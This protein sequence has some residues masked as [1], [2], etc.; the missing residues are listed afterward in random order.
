M[1]RLSAELQRFFFQQQ[2]LP[3]VQLQELL[4]LTQERTFGLLFVALALPS[5]LPVPA[6]GYAIPFGAVLLLLA[7]QL[8]WG[9]KLPWLPQRVRNYSIELERARHW[10][11]Q[12]LPWLQRIEAVARPRLSFV[13]TSPPGRMAL[14]GAIALMAASMMVPIPLTNTLPSIGIFV[15]GFGL[16]EDDGAIGL[17]GLAICTVSVALSAAIVASLVWGGTN[18]LQGVPPGS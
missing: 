14:G 4:A 12:G 3:Q 6:P 7:L 8:A 2:R 11:R 15:T 9:A 1:A 16:F 18:L 10:T 17:M 13:C 5:A